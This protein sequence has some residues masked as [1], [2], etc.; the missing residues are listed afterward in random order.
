MATQI[1]SAERFRQSATELAND[2]EKLQEAIK[3]FKI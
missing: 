3:Q 1:D 2:A